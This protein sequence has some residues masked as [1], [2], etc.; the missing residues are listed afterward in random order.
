MPPVTEGRSACCPYCQVRASDAITGYL[1]LC[2]VIYG[3][4]FAAAAGIMVFFLPDEL[5]ATAR[6]YDEDHISISASAADMIVMA[7][8]LL[9]L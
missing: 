7:V 4:L 3:S 9:F 8:S 2:D 6:G 5:L 1:I